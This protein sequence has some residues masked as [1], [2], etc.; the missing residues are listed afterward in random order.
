MN[1][2]INLAGFFYVTNKR[3]IRLVNMIVLSTETNEHFIQI[4]PRFYDNNLTLIVEDEF[5]D[6]EENINIVNLVNYEDGF[7][8]LSFQ[9][10]PIAKRR[11]KLT[12][13][14]IEDQ[15]LWKGKA[16]GQ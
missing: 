4:I 5:K 12:L 6:I 15:I 13:I 11:Y 10:Q 3:Q 7:M 2:V 9:F 8:D 16:K 14:N 1:P